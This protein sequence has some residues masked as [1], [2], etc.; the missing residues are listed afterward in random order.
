MILLGLPNV[1]WLALTIGLGAT[2]HGRVEGPFGLPMPHVLDEVLRGP[3]DSTLNLSTITEYDGRWWWLMAVDALLLLAAAFV[4]A[5]RSPARIRAWQHA[6]HMA[7]ALALTVLM[8]CLLCRIS[9]HYGLSV[10]GISDLGG[11]SGDLFLRPDL[12]TA[13]GFAVLWGL[14]AGFLGGLL[15]HRLRRRGEVAKEWQG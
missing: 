8:I 1:V 10:L 9:A 11:L 15:A 7:V 5:A 12:G 3:D 6:V 2:W 14:A 13:L 4:M